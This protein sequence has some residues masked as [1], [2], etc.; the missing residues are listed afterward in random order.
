MAGKYGLCHD[1]YLCTIQYENIQKNTM[2]IETISLTII[3]V[4]GF[5]FVPACFQK[6]TPSYQKVDHVS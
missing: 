1:H 6:F 3:E 5:V 4:F 2:K